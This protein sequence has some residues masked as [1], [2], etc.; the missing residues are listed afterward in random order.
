MAGAPGPD[1]WHLLRQGQRTEIGFN[2]R[3]SGGSKRTLRTSVRDD[4]Y[5]FLLPVGDRLGCQRGQILDE[6]SKWAVDGVSINSLLV[7]LAIEHKRGVPRGVE[8][9]I[10]RLADQTISDGFVR[11]VIPGGVAQHPHLGMEDGLWVDHGE[12]GTP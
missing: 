1:T 2:S 6:F 5:D 9:Q 3:F 12:A 8:G 10:P 7:Q 11:G 4:G